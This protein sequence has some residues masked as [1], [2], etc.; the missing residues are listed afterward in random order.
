M[1][2]YQL[3]KKCYV[4]TSVFFYGY[5]RKKKRFEGFFCGSRREAPDF[6][7]GFF[8]GF[9]A[10]KRPTFFFADFLRIFAAGDFSLDF[11]KNHSPKLRHIVILE[12][13]IA[14]KMKEHNVRTRQNALKNSGAPSG[15]PE[16]T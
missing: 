15:A 7:C 8:C 14:S 3:R 12:T 13:Q 11:T 1:R 10:A 9:E 5:F 2:M 6:F 16:Q 4:E